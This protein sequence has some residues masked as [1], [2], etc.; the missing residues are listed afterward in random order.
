LDTFLCDPLCPFVRLSSY[1]VLFLFGLRSNRERVIYFSGVFDRSGYT[2]KRGFPANVKIYAV[3]DFV[4]DADKDCIPL[5]PIFLSIGSFQSR[6]KPL[7]TIFFSF[8][9]TVYNFL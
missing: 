8:L 2:K 9:F 3:A 1:T 7:H 5:V 6:E 4:T